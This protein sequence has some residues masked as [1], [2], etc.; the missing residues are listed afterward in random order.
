MNST[1]KRQLIIFFTLVVLKPT[2]LSAQQNDFFKQIINESLKNNFKQELDSSAIPKVDSLSVISYIS[3]HTSK[4]VELNVHKNPL[5]KLG[6]NFRLN[7]LLKQSLNDPITEELKMF[8]MLTPYTNS[9]S[10]KYNKMMDYENL[11]PR[12]IYD[13]FTGNGMLSLSGAAEIV[14]SLLAKKKEKN[15]STEM[16][17]SESEKSSITDKTNQ[18]I[19]EVY[20]ADLFPSENDSTQS[21]FLFRKKDTIPNYELRRPPHY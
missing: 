15:T 6:Y 20:Y 3:L 14:G 19:W 16:K 21:E 17:Y 8:D 9:Y 5:P 10:I 12:R 7:A 11:L 2:F 4:L 13:D 1:G 18:L